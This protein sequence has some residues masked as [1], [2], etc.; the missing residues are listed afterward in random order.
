MFIA[1]TDSNTQTITYNMRM[2]I[3]DNQINPIAWEVSKIEDTIPKGLTQVVLKQDTFDP[4]RD[5]RELMIADYYKSNIEP[6][7]QPEII[8]DIKITYNS[9]AAIKVGGS[10]KIFSAVSKDTTLDN[11]LISWS[12]DGLS[13]EDYSSILSSN[14]IKIK[15]NRDFTLIGKVF[16]LSLFYNEKVVDQIPVEVISL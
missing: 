16:I 6:E 4:N 11:A 5:N 7:K 3:S 8:P 14:S 10:Y 2:L 12:I 1:P 9:S 13:K 15:A